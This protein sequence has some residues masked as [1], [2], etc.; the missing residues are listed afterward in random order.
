M[1]GRT[2]GYLMAATAVLSLVVAAQIRPELREFRPGEQPAAEV[3]V[4]DARGATKESVR[5]QR[6]AGRT[7][8]CYLQGP[9]LLRGLELCRAK[10]FRRYAL[11]AG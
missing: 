5:A 9:D 3:A 10:G 4:L 1:T 8:V 6:R 2:A 7:P 11:A